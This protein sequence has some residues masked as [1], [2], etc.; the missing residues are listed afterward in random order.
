MDPSEALQTIDDTKGA[1]T[2][3][4]ALAEPEM[5]KMERLELIEA[6]RDRGINRDK[7]YRIT[8]TLAEIGLIEEVTEQPNGRVK[9]VMTELTPRGEKIGEIIKQLI[10]TIEE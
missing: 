3:I 1:L 7:F 9:R 4:L 6:M 8:R 5:Q 10:K 2:Y